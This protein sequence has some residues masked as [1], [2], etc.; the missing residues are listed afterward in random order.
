MENKVMERVEQLEEKVKGLEGELA[1]TK[2]AQK[3]S[4]FRMFG[5]GILFLI[6]GVVAV[7]AIIAFVITIFTWFVEK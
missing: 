1:R 2:K 7:G 4:I 5:E 3:T 6:F